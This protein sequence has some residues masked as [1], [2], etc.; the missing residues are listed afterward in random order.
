MKLLAQREI[1]TGTGISMVRYLGERQQ[2]GKWELWIEGDDYPSGPEWVGAFSI[3]ELYGSVAPEWLVE[4]STEL[5]Q[6]W[7]VF[8]AA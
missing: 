4:S 6:Q 7:E 8:S 5:W 3:V 2:D 1:L